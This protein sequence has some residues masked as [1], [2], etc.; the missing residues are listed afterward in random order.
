MEVFNYM[1]KTLHTVCVLCQCDVKYCQCDKHKKQDSNYVF[2][3]IF[4]PA[5]IQ[6]RTVDFE[7]GL[8]KKYSG[9]TI[10]Q[11]SAVVKKHFMA[12]PESLKLKSSFLNFLLL[13]WLSEN[14]WTRILKKLLIFS[15][16]NAQLHCTNIY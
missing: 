12:M 2:L 16:V 4:S 6:N 15:S 3:S 10:T 7:S 8:K 13:D 1:N 11:Q 14:K 9:V 5:P